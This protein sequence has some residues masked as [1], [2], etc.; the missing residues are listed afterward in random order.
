MGAKAEMFFSFSYFPLFTSVLSV[1]SVAYASVT[2][3]TDLLS[4]RLPCQ[5]SRAERRLKIVTT[6]RTIEIK[7]FTREK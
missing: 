3:I 4:H 5:H 1:L 2:E 7:N 6:N